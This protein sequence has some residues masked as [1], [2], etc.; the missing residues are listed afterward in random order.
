MSTKRKKTPATRFKITCEDGKVYFVYATDVLQ[1][2]QK[3]KEG[4][5]SADPK[6]VA[7]DPVLAKVEE[8]MG[9][10]TTKL[11]DG[12]TVFG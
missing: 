4:R 3:F 7:I 5:P 9:I 2:T 6:G 11:Q 1:A 10:W 12:R 8:D